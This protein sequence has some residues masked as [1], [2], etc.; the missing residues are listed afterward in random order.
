MKTLQ[1]L[2]VGLCVASTITLSVNAH[3][4]SAEKQKAID[5]VNKAVESYKKDGAA[6][7]FAEISRP[8]GNFHDGNLYVFVYDLKGEVKAHGFKPGWIGKNKLD[9]KDAD[10]KA[11]IKD[12][13]ATK[14]DTWLDYKMVDPATNKTEPKTSY[15]KKVD[16]FF[17][18]CGIYKAK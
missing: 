8:K 11:Y 13:V 3:A 12:M 14:S 10:G 15:I 1:Y 6:K 18:G 16:D 4:E 5:L 17:F 2:L 9:Y 7:T